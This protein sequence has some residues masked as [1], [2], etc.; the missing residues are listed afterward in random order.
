MR[1]I[2]TY[3]KSGIR[4]YISNSIFRDPQTQTKIKSEPMLPGKTYFVRELRMN[5]FIREGNTIENW[6]R[7][8][9]QS[10]SISNNRWGKLCAAYPKLNNHVK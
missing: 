9:K 10:G 6:L 1:G 4:K 5:I 8:H 7:L 2:N 3:Q